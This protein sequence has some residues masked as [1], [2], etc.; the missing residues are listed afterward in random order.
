MGSVEDGVRVAL[1]VAGTPASSSIRTNLFGHPF[2]ASVAAVELARASGCALIPVY[3]PR[4]ENN[5][6]GHVLPEIQYDRASLRDRAATTE[7]TQRV[8]DVFEPVIRK[9]LDQ[10]YHFVPIWPENRIKSG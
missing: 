2:A 4:Y 7:L 8:M 3:L 1:W 6:G 10:W 9:H 5:Y